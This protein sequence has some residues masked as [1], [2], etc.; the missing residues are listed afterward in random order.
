MEAD[1]I[2]RLIFELRTLKLQAESL[3]AEIARKEKELEILREQL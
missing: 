3:A 1:K 2:Q